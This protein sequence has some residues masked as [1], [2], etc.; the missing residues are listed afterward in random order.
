M[1]LVATE[2]T[3]AVA[4]TGILPG[5][6]DRCRIVDRPLLDYV[7]TVSTGHPIR[8][9]AQELRFRSPVSFGCSG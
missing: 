7:E 9:L 6:D 3:N 2:T 5:E 8:L 4:L 1:R